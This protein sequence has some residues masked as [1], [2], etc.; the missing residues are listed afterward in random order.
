M[1]NTIMAALNET[2]TII[3]PAKEYQPLRLICA[4]ITHP[5]PGYRICR[6]SDQDLYVLEY[7]I[8]GKIEVTYGNRHFTAREGDVYFHQPG[9]AE[10]YHSDPAEPC[11]KIWFN[12][13]GYLMDCFCKAYHL[14]GSVF[15]PQCSLKKDFFETLEQI[16]QMKSGPDERLA[17][18]IHKIMVKLNEWRIKHPELQKSQE[19][20]ALKEYLDQHWQDNVSISTLAG[21]IGKSPAQTLRIFRKDWNDTPYGYLQKRR[22]DA[23]CQ[24]LENTDNS[25]KEIAL[26]LGFK[27]EFYF[28]NWFKK[29]TTEA[30]LFYRNRFRK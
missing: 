28:S 9:A 1:R 16:R 6:R 7:I 2:I 30:P 27:D 23:A 15:F 13:T 10:E 24:Y 18:Q 5:D 22:Q 20:N 21:H 3:P 11:C 4:G 17:L 8:S 29:R 12:L 26:L 19:G 14:Y 25:I